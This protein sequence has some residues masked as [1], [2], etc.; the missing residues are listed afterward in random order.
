MKNDRFF[1]FACLTILAGVFISLVHAG[2][3]SVSVRC[4]NGHIFT[5]QAQFSRTAAPLPAGAQ[6]AQSARS[7][8]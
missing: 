7:A 1:K 8:E 2:P 4:P 3:R 5:S 6:A